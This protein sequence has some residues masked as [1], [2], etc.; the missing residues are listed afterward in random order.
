MELIS[1]ICS[2]IVTIASVTILT[3]GIAWVIM[4]VKKNR[5]KKTGAWAAN[6][7]GVLWCVYAGWCAV[8][9]VRA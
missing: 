5:R 6:R 1:G 2:V 4:A 3:I 8:G 9:S 7:T